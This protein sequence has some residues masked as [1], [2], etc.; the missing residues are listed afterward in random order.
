MTGPALAQRESHRAIHDA[1]NGEAL[2]I[3]AALRRFVADSRPGDAARA[4][5]AFLESFEAKVLRHAEVE[6]GGLYVAVRDAIESDGDEL[7]ELVRE[8]AGLRALHATIA[9]RLR[10]GPPDD[11]ALGLMTAL[12]GANA[13][14]GEHE[15]AVL[16]RLSD[17]ID[18]ARAGPEAADVE[19]G[20]PLNDFDEG[21]A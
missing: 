21:D 2:L 4:G 10:R 17:R 3:L 7:G 6:E 8:H 15:E 12:I 5:E 16:F 11:G 20:L 9:G 1:A 18:L 14:H 13:A 19:D